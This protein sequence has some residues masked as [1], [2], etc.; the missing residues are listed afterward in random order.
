MM[1]Q[2]VISFLIN[3]S[4]SDCSN[5][6]SITSVRSMIFTFCKSRLFWSRCSAEYD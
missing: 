3:F 1:T 4:L 5:Q 2:K 6:T